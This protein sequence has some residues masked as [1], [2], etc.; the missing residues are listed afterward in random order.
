MLDFFADQNNFVMWLTFLVI[1]GAM[2]F[3]VTEWASIEVTSLG[4]LVALML[5]ATLLPAGGFDAESLLSGF[6]NPALFTILAL[7]VVGQG[8]IQTEALA[9]LTNWLT[10]LWPKHPMRVVILSLVIAGAASAIVNNTPVVIVFIPVL[11]SILAK[12]NMPASKFMMPLSFMTILGGMTTVLGS[13]TNLL[14]AGVARQYGIES[15]TF[16]S[17]AIPGLIMALIGWLYVLF[18]AP[19]IIP[20]N[21]TQNTGAQSRNTQFISEI[22]L[23]YGH[24][25]I[26]EKTIAGMFPN[27]TTMTIRAVQRGKQTFLP[28]FDDIT[29]KTGDTLIIAAT[30][31]ALTK[32]LRDWKAFEDTASIN[33]NSTE[34]ESG[35]VLCE[36]MVPPS[37]R[38]VGYGVDQ[39]GFMAKHDLLILGMERRSRMPRQ[40]MSE[41]R[42]EAGDVLLIAGQPRSFENIR[43]LQDLIVIEWSAAE[44]KPRGHALRSLI[45][46]FAT[47][48]VIATGL[49]PT[50]VPAIIGAFVMVA[51]G[52]LNV[53]QA[54]RSLDRKIIL[55][56]G[57]SLA[58]ATAMQFTGGAQFIAN[59]AIDALGTSSPAIVMSGLFI[60][61]AAFT[62]F[63]SNNATAVLFTP[64]AIAAANSLGVDP[65]P[66]IVSVILGANASFAS[67]VGY[68]TNLLVMSAGHYKF[69][70]F[71]IVGMPLIILMWLVFSIVA[72]WYY[73]I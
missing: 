24:P 65:L 71:F 4:T 12:R 23:T 61:V 13:S 69:R 6:S 18:I 56:V 19:R 8:L 66:L 55:L 1:A 51:S 38:L 35:V 33:A 5:I 30:R 48:A 47:V 7:L 73:G 34:S 50:V 20:N 11:V 9:D 58:M 15:V 49:M 45:I 72:P 62:N 28:P 14:A 67:P 25:L 3:Y 42:L 16:F 53:R 41:I 64:I 36:A 40:R 2:L 31:D 52:C 60:L 44:V 46:F 17:F 63:L 57:S 59:G 54:A 29:L 21:E 10:N 22:H 39:A 27:L 70:D 37:S 32:A 26:G 68:Q 43:G